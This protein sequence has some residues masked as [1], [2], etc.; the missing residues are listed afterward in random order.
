MNELN[1][2][3]KKIES[4]IKIRRLSYL[5]ELQ[6]LTKIRAE[7][8]IRF[9]EMKTSQQKYHQGVEELNLIKSTPNRSNLENIENSVDFLKHNWFQHY[10]KFKATEKRESDQIQ[11]FLEAEKSIKSLEKISENFRLSLQNEIAKI[12]QKTSDDYSI[13]YKLLNS[14]D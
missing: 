7:K 6:E 5:Q 9:Q 8:S 11:R 10:K 13:L 12:E 4:I 14:K 3:I 1:D 2:K